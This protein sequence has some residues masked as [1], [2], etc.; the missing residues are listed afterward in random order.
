M[1]TPAAHGFRLAV[2]VIAPDLSIAY[3]LDLP[4]C[5]SSTATPAEA[6]RRAPERIAAHLI[7]RAEHDCSLPIADGTP[8]V[9]VVETIADIASSADPNHSMGAFFADDQRPLAAWE[10]RALL[11][12]L[13]W[14]HEDLLAAIGKSQTMRIA[15]AY[16]AVQT[17]PLSRMRGPDHNQT[18]HPDFAEI[19]T[20][21]ALVENRYYSRLNLGLDPA[22]LPNDPLERLETVCAN[23]RAQHLLLTGMETVITTGDE[24]WSARKLVRR[25]LWHRRDHSE[26]IVQLRAASIG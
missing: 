3:A 14:T 9:D 4:G 1:T 18:L 25:T 5:F 8:A 15:G 26:Q 7:W 10:I 12:L 20:H 13:D 2:E 17:K 16:A 19:V 22:Q 11:P 24:R 23:T 6:I 21:L